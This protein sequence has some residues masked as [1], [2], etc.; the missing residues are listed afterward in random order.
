MSCAG[1]GQGIQNLLLLLLLL[2]P[3]LPVH[4]SHLDIHQQPAQ[5][6]VLQAGQKVPIHHPLQQGQHARP[7]QHLLQQLRGTCQ[8]QA[9]QPNTTA[10]AGLS[11]ISSWHLLLLLLLHTAMSVRPARQYKLAVQPNN[12]LGTTKC[13][14]TDTTTSCH[15]CQHNTN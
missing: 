15:T 14:H 6:T 4:S 2:L 11:L 10:A 8:P 7:G 1:D 13:C 12:S 9:A 3:V 5:V